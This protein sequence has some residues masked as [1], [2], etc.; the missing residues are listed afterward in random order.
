MG[1]IGFK[2]ERYEV[3]WPR[4]YRKLN[5]PTN[6]ALVWGRLRSTCNRLRH[7]AAPIQ[8]YDGIIKAQEDIGIIEPHQ[9]ILISEETTVMLLIVYDASAS[10]G[11]NSASLNNALSHD[12]TFP[13]QT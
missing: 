11:N 6:C 8:R 13:K 9:P 12:R 5:L 1:N 2:E 4:T 7:N 10:T 3:H